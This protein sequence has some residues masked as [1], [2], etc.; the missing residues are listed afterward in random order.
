MSMEV[1][2][3]PQQGGETCNIEF[4]FNVGEDSVQAIIAEMQSELN[5]DLTPEEATFV[6][7]KIEDEL[8]RCAVVLDSASNLFCGLLVSFFC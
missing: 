6:H 7:R 8:R 1:G 3:L 2:N 5:L 4:S